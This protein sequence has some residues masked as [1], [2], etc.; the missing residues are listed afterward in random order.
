MEN[1]IVTPL[2]AKFYRRLA[3]EIFNQSKKISKIFLSKDSTIIIK[4][5]DLPLISL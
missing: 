1:E 3:D 2:K 5:S 4:T